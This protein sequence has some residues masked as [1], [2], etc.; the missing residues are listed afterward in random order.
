M[1][2]LRRAFSMS[3]WGGGS[4]DG[5]RSDTQ[6]T[7]SWQPS[8]RHMD[9]VYASQGRMIVERAEDLDRNSG[10]VNG[11]IDRSVEA[12]IGNGLQL[13]PTPIYDLLG[14]DVKWSAQWSRQ[15]R[16]RWRAWSEDPLFRS[17]ARMRFNFGTQTKLAYLYFRRS[18]EALAEL[19]LDE[20]GSVNPLNVLLIDPKRLENPNGAPN[21]TK[22]RNG[23]EMANGVPVAGH[24]LK[25]HPDDPAAGMDATRT[26]RIPFRGATG[27]P[28]LIHVINPRYIEQ[29][30]GFS[31]LVESMVPAKML[32][33]FERAV[34]NR[35]MLEAVMG[36][37]IESGGTTADVEQM[38]AP[39]GRETPGI[40]AYENYIGYRE[41][42]P[43]KV[44]GD[45]FIRHLLP[46][47]KVHNTPAVTP[48]DN[49]TEF[50]KA[51][52]SKIAASHGLSYAQIS[53]NWADINYSSARAMLNEI[54]RRIEQ[55]RDYF[56]THFLLPIYVTWLEWEV[57]NG[58][59]KVPGGPSKFYSSIS[60]LSSSR[61]IGPSRGSVDP[62]KEA[63]AR[64]LEEAAMRKSPIQHVLEDGN[65]PFDVLDQIALF[66]SGVEDRDLDPP[67]YNV[68]A[69]TS[70]S[71]DSSSGSSG[72]ENDRDGDGKPNEDQKRKKPQ[73]AGQ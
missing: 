5:G 13:W 64:N 30:R 31:Q 53:G 11:A 9:D 28:K 36:F 23:I 2:G 46:G 22:Y 71:D 7:A 61:W 54:W 34:I 27:T 50:Q 1:A 15:T 62:L 47:E 45:L 10:W 6:E 72:T 26:T 63:S 12:V 8:R 65:D 41:K 21:G 14:R 67:N 59:I 68:K 43:I 18:G 44:I 66:R 20:R 38:I 25:W 39:T 73:E 29:S 4:F 35:A 24:V 19:R 3:Y 52:L 55:E 33:R 16:A 56:A 60:A 37:F 49:Y 17:D 42:N 70:G 40:A 57:A 51:Q 69:D 32:D 58:A 48:G